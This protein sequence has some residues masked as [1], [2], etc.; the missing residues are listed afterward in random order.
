M[1]ASDFEQRRNDI[2]GAIVEAYVTTG[3]P[4]GSAVLSRKLRQSLSPATIRNVMAE[5]EEAGYLEQP[6]TS[7]GRVPTDRG[8]R[9]YVDSVMESPRLSG[10][11]LR[12]MG[13]AIGQEA[14]A[15]SLL[16]RAAE[17]LAELTHQASIV[18]VP[19]VKHTTIRQIELLPLSVHR[20][21]CVVVGDAPFLISHAVDLEEPISRDE[22]LSLAHFLTTELAGRPAREVL[23]VL[24]R[25]ML[26]G[27]DSFYHLVKRS[28]AILQ[29]VL[30]VEPEERLHIEGAMHLFEHPE[31]ANH[32]QQAHELLRQLELEQGLLD[33]LRG[34]LP[35]QAEGARVRIGREVGLDGLD[36]C[37]YVV[38]PIGLQRVVL[39]GIGILG[40]R[41]M[42]YRRMQALVEGVAA[43]VSD[44]LSQQMGH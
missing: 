43:L 35:A 3:A 38:A 21:L 44:S 42:D 8:Y 20:L 22:A 13:V 12:Q 1:T 9:Y 17:V 15:Q 18:V 28:L 29:A 36:A 25:R 2:L 10:D 31:F 11:E 23:V 41:R 32:P 24:E 37:S 39:G 6:H 14:D 33:R 16:E 30:A 7:A 4:V 19:T 34:D 26:S 40:P 27:S 5:L